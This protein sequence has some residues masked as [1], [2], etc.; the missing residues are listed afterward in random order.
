M[1]DF[2][3][4]PKFIE[5]LESFISHSCSGNASA[6]LTIA[7]HQN[8]LNEQFCGSFPVYT[9]KHMGPA[10]GFGAYSVYWLHMIIPDGKLSRTQNP[11]CY[12][13]KIDGVVSFLCLD[14]HI[15]N[16]KDSELR[17]IAIKRL[18]DVLEVINSSN[19]VCS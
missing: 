16:Y 18:D 10:Q 12:L 15:N 9:P 4:H 11:K 13:L 2:S 6:A 8:L 7:Q 17:K 19:Q 3:H 5:E 1:L 14:S